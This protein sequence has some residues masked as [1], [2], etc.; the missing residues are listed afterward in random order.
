MLHCMGEE[1][2]GYCETKAQ[3][4]SSEKQKACF[5]VIKRTQKLVIIGLGVGP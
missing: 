2:R 3:T 1:Q 4:C 5:T